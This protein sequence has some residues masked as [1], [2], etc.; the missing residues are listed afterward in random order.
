MKKTLSFIAIYL[1][2]LYFVYTNHKV[3]LD[4][5][6]E[7]DPSLLP[8]MFLL[9]TLFGVIP[10]IPFS[11]FSGL[12][13]SKYGL[14]IGASINWFGTVAASVIIYL[15]ARYGFSE[16]FTSYLK[17]F[18][19]ITKF[20]ELITRN[21]FMA[22]LF[23]R[24]IPIVPPPVVNIYSGLIKINLATYTIASIIGKLPGMVLYAYVGDRLFSSVGDLVYGLVFYGLFLLLILIIYYL[25]T[26]KS[27][28]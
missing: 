18:K 13:G 1:G 6:S 2:L 15:L 11:V 10:V 22:I 24:L 12:M 14:V 7:S 21:A 28:K 4:W 16:Y 19:G 25:W 3:I 20:N 26:K 23:T 8:L 17:R 9:S 5:I 27:K